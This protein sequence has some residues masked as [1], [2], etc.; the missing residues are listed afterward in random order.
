MLDADRDTLLA[1]ALEH[2]PMD[3]TFAPFVAWLREQDVR[4]TLVCDGF[5]F[6]IEPLLAAAGIADIARHHERADLGRR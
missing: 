2:C 6:Y 1:F 3:P 4:V 5:G